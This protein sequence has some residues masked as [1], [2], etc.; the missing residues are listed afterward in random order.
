VRFADK[1]FERAESEETKQVCT[2]FSSWDGE[3][4]YT[5]RLVVQYVI[6]PAASEVSSAL[7]VPV[8]A[9]SK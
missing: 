9:D 4:G 3:H 8:S 2:G 5:A 7:L 6:A 1:A